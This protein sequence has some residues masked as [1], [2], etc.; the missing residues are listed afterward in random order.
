MIPSALIEYVPLFCTFKTNQSPAP[1][2]RNLH[3]L[4]VSGEKYQG[5]VN[6]WRN[7][8]GVSGRIGTKHSFGDCCIL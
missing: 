4:R 8:F 7:L 5:S 6:V 2:A 1:L 3:G